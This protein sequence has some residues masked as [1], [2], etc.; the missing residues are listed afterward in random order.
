MLLFS[1]L[2]LF[3]IAGARPMMGGEEIRTK[4]DGIDIAVVFD[5]SLSMLA[6]DENGPRYLRGR[7]ML[8][9]AVN[10]LSGD[11]ISLIPF[12]GSAFL[13]L[14]LTDDYATAM[15]VISSLEPGIIER[16]GSALSTSIE[17]AVEVLQRS[18]RDSDKLIVLVSDGEDPDM[19]FEKIKK[20]LEENNV[21][22]A[23]LILGTEDGAP[24]R[25]GDSY[26]RDEKG[27]TVISKVNRE[28]FTKAVSE[29]G[30]FELKSGSSISQY[31]QVFKRSVVEEERTAYVFTER[32]QV[33]LF[34]GIFAFFFFIVLSSGRRREK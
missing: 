19:K 6:E 23:L 28:F 8:L 26:L 30:A 13:Q 20:L 24:V 33:P 9:E 5:V 3:T 1:A 7:N 15:S 32:F 14:P 27:K 25:I 18:E 12:A 17:M 10:A 21:K 22:L 16:Q 29:L 34:F 2:T 31:I 11:R 4:S